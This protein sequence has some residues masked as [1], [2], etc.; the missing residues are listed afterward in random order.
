MQNTP[1]SSSA[2]CLERP[3]TRR[4]RRWTALLVCAALLLGAF[5]VAPQL[6]PARAPEPA[7][8]DLQGY[9]ELLDRHKGKPVLVTFW[10]TW[11]EPCR[12]EYPV[13]NELARQYE[14]K[15]LLVIGISF[16]EDA[17]M[18]LVR[19]FLERYRPVFSNYRL[20]TANQEEFWHGVH[21]QWTGTIPAYF[22]YARDGRRVAALVGTHT[23]E[24]MEKAIQKALEAPAAGTAAPSH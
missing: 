6:K 13:V 7:L 5:P 18:N 16:D 20:H 14:K 9:R 1:Q 21:A 24:Q 15:G 10:A 23:R 4:P 3:K 17:E 19:I 22:L 2:P 8:I 11:C 12:E